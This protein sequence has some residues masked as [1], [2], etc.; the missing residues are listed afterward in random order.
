MV[1]FDAVFA[2]ALF[3]HLQQPVRA[4]S[5]MRRVLRSSGFVG[6]RSPDWA[7]WFVCPPCALIDEA[8]RL[9]KK[10]QISNGGNP[11]VGRALRGLFEGARIFERFTLG[12]LRACTNR[13]LRGLARQ[14]LGA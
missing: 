3:E 14:L 4:L 9:F 11:H 12:F 6:L 1:T 7:G 2:H 8:F 5:E 13:L 10:I